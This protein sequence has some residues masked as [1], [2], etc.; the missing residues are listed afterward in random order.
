M[1]EARKTEMGLLRRV[2]LLC[3]FGR[4]TDR[5]VRYLNLDRLCHHQ[6]QRSPQT[7]DR[8][9]WP[10]LEEVRLDWHPFQSFDWCAVNRLE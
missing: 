8:K 6:R 7:R 4:K 10:V 1:D 9:T 3:L 2:C 5:L